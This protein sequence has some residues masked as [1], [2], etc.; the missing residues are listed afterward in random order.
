MA[1]EICSGWSLHYILKKVLLSKLMEE[2]TIAKQMFN[3]LK[4]IN[5]FKE[6]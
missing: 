5:L 3:L 4:K 6:V 2:T 1:I